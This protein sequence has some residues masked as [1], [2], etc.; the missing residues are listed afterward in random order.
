MTKDKRKKRW[1]DRKDGYIVKAPGLQTV[2]TTLMP[3]RTDC[4]DYWKNH[5]FD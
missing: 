5:I 4:D 3:N 2:M 1:G